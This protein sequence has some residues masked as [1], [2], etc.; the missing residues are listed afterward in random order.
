MTAGRATTA[1]SGIRR[2]MRVTM[3]ATTGTAIAIMAIMTDGTIGTIKRCG[4]G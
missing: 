1:S 2:G 3:T 4:N